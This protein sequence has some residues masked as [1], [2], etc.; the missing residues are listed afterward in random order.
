MVIQTVLGKQGETGFRNAGGG[1]FEALRK[2]QCLLGSRHSDSRSVITA[3]EIQGDH[4][5]AVPGDHF[6][7]GSGG[8]SAGVTLVSV[9][10]LSITFLPL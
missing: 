3:H 4:R 2:Q 9:V 6:D 1:N 7:L 10:F 5:G 8:Y